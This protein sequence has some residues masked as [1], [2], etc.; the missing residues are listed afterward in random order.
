MSSE[1]MET[2]VWPDHNMNETGIALFHNYTI[3]NSSDTTTAM[4][5]P[6]NFCNLKP[7]LEQWEVDLSFYLNG[8]ITL[9]TIVL[10]L[11]GNT[12]TVIVLTNKTMRTSTNCFLMALAIWDSIV[13]LVT[14]FLISL[15]EFTDEYKYTVFPYIVAFIYPLGL[16]AQMIT[17]WL[18]VSFTVERYIAVCHPLK[19]AGMCT[20]N[21][22][23]MVIV[24]V[25]FVSLLYNIPRWLEYQVLA[26]THPPTNDSC[27]IIMP[28]EFNKDPMYN[29]IYFGW[30]YFLVMCVIPLVSLAVLNTFLILAVRRSKAQRKDM[31]V[32]QSR[33]NN[34]TIMLISVVLLFM[35]FQVPALIYNMAYAIDINA[36]HSSFGWKILSTIRNFLVNLNSAVNFI[37]YCAL[38]QKFRRTFV[39]IFCPKMR[40]N[41]DNFNSF[42]NTFKMDKMKKANGANK[43]V[44]MANK[45]NHTTSTTGDS[46]VVTKSAAISRYSP[47][48][49]NDSNFTDNSVAPGSVK[50]DKVE[51]PT[52]GNLDNNVESSSSDALDSN[53]LDS[54]VQTGH[55]ADGGRVCN[56][57]DAEEKQ[58]LSN[59]GTG[60]NV[61]NGKK[62]EKDTNDNVENPQ[63]EV[64]KDDKEPIDETN[65]APND[66]PETNGKHP[67]SD[68]HLPKEEFIPNENFIENENYI[69]I[70]KSDLDAPLLLLLES[71][72][73]S[74]IL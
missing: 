21:R 27:M 47:P 49:S 71:C 43:Y 26:F 53:V 37:L 55:N 61:S 11:V 16:V 22:A 66:K 13:L 31:N 15:G 69:D 28:T 10:G 12:L 41:L 36:V 48:V 42:S 7:T 57:N 40:K 46:G 63:P 1:S 24:G 58:T 29:K 8:V 56:E 44:K 4:Q 20:I 74:D 3:G 38:G 45:N 17:I 33:E 19:A 52:N 64:S 50:N 30:S 73:E 32:R 34:V 25:C 39:R 2:V 6:P 35:L 65:K 14:F 62:V 18:T 23:R 51:K 60:D 68:N 67:S 59:V 70:A 9:F 72:R 5:P 54:N